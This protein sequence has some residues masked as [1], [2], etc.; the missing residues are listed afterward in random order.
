MTTSPFLAA[1]MPDRQ[2][3][4]PIPRSASLPLYGRMVLTCLL[5]IA[6]FWGR[7]WLAVRLSHWTALLSGLALPV[8]AVLNGEVVIF[9]FAL[10]IIWWKVLAREKKFHAPLFITCILIVGDA[11][12][13]ILENHP[14]AWLARA[15]SGLITSYSP[16][17]IT[18]LVTVATE[19]FLGRLV[20]GKWPYPASAYVSGISAGILIKSP[21]LWP[22][23]LGGM[24][25]ITSKYVFR[26]GDRHLWNPTN[27]GMTVM[28]LLAPQHVATLTVQAGNEIWSV[29]VI[30]IMGGFILQQLKRIHI[31]IA[32]LLAFLPLSYLRSVSGNSWLTEL[33]P[34]T[35]TMF[36]LYIFFMITD[37]K[38]T[39]H[40]RWSQALVAALVAVMDTVC[41]MAF[42]DIHSLY[43]ALFIV[44]AVSNL[45]EIYYARRKAR[46]HRPQ[47]HVAP[48][49]V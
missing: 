8:P 15:T 32:F 28:L 18:I 48:L 13:S 22:F 4:E 6:H 29:I 37:P 20:Y 46:R 2:H 5:L 16:T 36:Q 30:W 25:S 26:I 31:P 38:T 23:V 47:V 34:M 27:F 7:Q 39:T 43:H 41:R 45:V 42:R 35:S 12:F 17:F 1:K 40:T 10:F 9:L 49:P 11:A 21:D 44:G 3:Q 14:S 33:A 24:I 19:L